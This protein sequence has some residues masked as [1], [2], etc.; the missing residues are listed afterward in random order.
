MDD[1][2]RY[3]V[4]KTGSTLKEAFELVKANHVAA[5]PNKGF[6]QLLIDLEIE[7]F[8]KASVTIDE[9]FDFDPVSRKGSWKNVPWDLAPVSLEED[10]KCQEDS[11]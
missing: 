8:G 11:R 1:H 3:L 4:S 10:K 6:F 7:K 9:F 2:R 5:S